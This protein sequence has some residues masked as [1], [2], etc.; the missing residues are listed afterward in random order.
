M[1]SINVAGI[2]ILLTIIALFVLA[3]L[4]ADEAV[5][6]DRFRS[7]SRHRHLRSGKLRNP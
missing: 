3:W 5:G 7:G 6:P 2:M 1:H 4:V